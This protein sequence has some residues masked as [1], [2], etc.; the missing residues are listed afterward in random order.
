[1]YKL[2]EYTVSLLHFDNGFKD[3]IGKVWTAVGNPVISPDQ[4]KF[5]GRS[6]YL[7]GNSYLT[8][9]ANNDFNFGTG[10]FTVDW[11]E[12][13]ISTDTIYPIVFSASPSEHNGILI[14]HYYNGENLCY[15]SSFNSDSW[16]VLEGLNLGKADLNVWNHFALVKQGNKFYGFKN[17]TLISTLT[18]SRQIDSAGDLEL[19]AYTGINT[20]LNYLFSGYIDEF[21]ISNIARWTEDFDPTPVKKNCILRITMNDSSEREYELNSTEVEVFI[22]WCNRTVDTGDSYYVFDKTVGSQNSKEYL[23]FEKIISF[24]VIDIS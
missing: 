14:G 18:N 2:D 10:D 6:L 4:S 5:G 7:D 11:W 23:F 9:P 22:T 17:G 20:N 13:R 1:M 21:R 19:G 16:D 24:E 12:Y 15:A 8:T 3:E